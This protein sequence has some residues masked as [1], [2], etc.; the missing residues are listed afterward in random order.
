M[1]I[2]NSFA[3]VFDDKEAGMGRR[4]GVMGPVQ[5]RVLFEDG[6]MTL[7][8][9]NERVKN[10]TALMTFPAVM[11]ALTGELLVLVAFENRDIEDDQLWKSSFLAALFC[12]VEVHDTP[13][14]NEEM[15]AVAKSTSVSLEGKSGRLRLV[16]G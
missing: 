7:S 4:I 6:N 13:V 16:A 15:S 8:T 9:V 10:L 11:I 14:G 12:D 3:E 1:A 5:L 2:R